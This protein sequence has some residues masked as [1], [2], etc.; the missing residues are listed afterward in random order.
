MWRT[1]KGFSEI[2]SEVRQPD[3]SQ[4]R[5]SAADSG[6]TART[7]TDSAADT[8]TGTA[9]DSKARADTGTAVY[10]TGTGT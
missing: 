9:A 4:E 8:R 6:T 1:V 3:G 5:S 10:G 2:L 7:D